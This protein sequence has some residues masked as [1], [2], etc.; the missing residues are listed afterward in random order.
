MTDKEQT[1]E[2]YLKDKRYC[3]NCLAHISDKVSYLKEKHDIV[4][5]EKDVLEALSLKEQ[6]VRNEKI[7]DWVQLMHLR[8]WVHPL[9][10]EREK[11]EA[12]ILGIKQSIQETIERELFEQENI[13]HNCPQFQ[14]NFKLS[15]LLKAQL[16]V[17]KELT[18]KI[19]E[20]K[21]SKE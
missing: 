6:E 2:E 1:A 13:E 21:E 8:Y 15:D 20:E 12:R 5:Y 9:I 10:K 4:Y 11:T 3:I 16:K 18:S 17:V 14:G 7:S 19:K